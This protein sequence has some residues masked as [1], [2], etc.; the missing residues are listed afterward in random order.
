VAVVRKRSIPTERPPL[1]DE[2]SANR[3]RAEGVAWW[4]KQI[5][6][7]VNLGFVDSS[8]SRLSLIIRENQATANIKPPQCLIKHNRMNVYGRVEVLIHEFLTLALGGGYWTDLTPPP[9]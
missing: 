1:V 7:A 5:P 9:L 2:V 8:L 4:E 6:T 3:L